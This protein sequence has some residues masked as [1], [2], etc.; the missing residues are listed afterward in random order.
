M[1]SLH[2]LVIIASEIKAIKPIKS[3]FIIEFEVS[4]EYGPGK[5]ARHNMSLFCSEK[6]LEDIKTKIKIGTVCE[7]S[8]ATFTEFTGQNNYDPSKFYSKVWINTGS[9]NI[10]FLKIPFYY[11]NLPDLT[12]STEE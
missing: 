1:L 4:S 12:K 7:I 9:K 8:H 11:E 2:G 10:K 5:L 6:D 3:S